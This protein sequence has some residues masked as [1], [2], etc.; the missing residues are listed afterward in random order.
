MDPDVERFLDQAEHT[1]DRVAIGLTGPHELVDLADRFA[2]R[3]AADQA[4]QAAREGLARA[5]LRARAKLDQLQ[6]ELNG[7]D[8]R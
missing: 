5:R 2:A 6:A 3:V 4:V 1:F 7:S 8:D